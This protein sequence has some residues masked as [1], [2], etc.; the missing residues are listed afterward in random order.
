[1]L[2]AQRV[3]KRLKRKGIENSVLRARGNS[4]A[5]GLGGRGGVGAIALR[6]GWPNH[7]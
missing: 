1:M 6:K 4:F 2:Y 5:N 3:C 7:K